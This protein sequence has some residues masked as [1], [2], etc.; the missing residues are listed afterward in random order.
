V[1]APG[2]TAE[3]DAWLVGPSIKLKAGA[4]ELH[5]FDIA[6]VEDGPVAT[7]R[8]DVALPAGF[9]GAWAG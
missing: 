8:A 4:T 7:W 9:H 5:V 6:R 2:A 3:T 1:N